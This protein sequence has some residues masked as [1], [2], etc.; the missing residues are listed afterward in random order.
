LDEE[1]PVATAVVLQK[2]EECTDHED[3]CEPTRIMKLIEVT[4]RVQG[5]VPTIVQAIKDTMRF[6]GCGHEYDCCG[7]WSHHVTDV[8]QRKN[9]PAQ[10][11][12]LQYASRNY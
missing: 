3:P 11:V 12:V 1:A 6:S 4:D 9:N 10:F 8:F 2:S 5:D 7:C